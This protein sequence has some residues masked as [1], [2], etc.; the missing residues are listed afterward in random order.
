MPKTRQSAVVFLALFLTACFPLSSRHPLGNRVF[1]QQ[2]VG[3]WQN[4][5][6]EMKFTR[7]GRNTL[8]LKFSTLDEDTAGEPKSLYYTVLPSQIKEKRFLSVTQFFPAEF[9]EDYAAVNDISYTE[10]RRK[11]RNRDKRMNGY[12]LGYYEFREEEGLEHLEIYL[13]DEESEIVKTALESGIL[14]GGTVVVYD[15]ENE[16][17]EL[18][19]LTSSSGSLTKF[20]GGHA[21]EVKDLFGF[22]IA[23][24]VRTK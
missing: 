9:L 19:Y 11:F 3:V 6:V 12:Y 13:I 1:D 16:Q 21:L 17:G 10:A 8:K 23:D 2:L 7:S 14:K 22:E 15:E 18:L 5:D 4:D 20:V 24:L